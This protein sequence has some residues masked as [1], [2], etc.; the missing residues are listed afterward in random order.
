M[1]KNGK[2]I[3]L[4]SLLVISLLV[5]SFSLA[6]RNGNAVACKDGIDND[7]DTYTD[8]PADPGCSSRNDNN[9]RGTT[10]CDNGVDNDGDGAIDYPTDTGCSSPTDSSERGTIACD[11]GNDND[12]D[13]Y[14]DYLNDPGCTGIGDTSEY[15]TVQCDNG[16]D[17]DNDTKTDSADTGCSS[18]TGTTETNCGDS[19]ISG[20]EVCDG[21]ALGGQ[22]CSS[23][24]FSGGTLSCNSQC[25]GFVTTGCYSNTCTDTDS[26]YNVGTAGTASGMYV[27]S[28]YSYSDSCTN[29]TNLNEHYCSG[30]LHYSVNYDCAVNFT[31]CGSGA[32]I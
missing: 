22:T 32:C 11:D 28:S 20:S 15:G 12:G 8:Y 16:L 6:A 31:T 3:V 21:S 7:G 30:N 1:N 4:L 5:M 13:S 2:Q 17:D 27:G 25:T 29:G 18:P 14:S 26:G 24:G 19:V 10:I 9:E 23:Q